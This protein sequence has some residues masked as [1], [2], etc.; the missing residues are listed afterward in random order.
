MKKNIII[1]ITLIVG[2]LL[3]IYFFG[4]EGLGLR[5]LVGIGFGYVLSRG[6]YGFAGT[7]NRAYRANSYKLMRS[8]MDLFMISS[9]VVALLLLAF[10]SEA[11]N[12][13]I[14]PINL[15]LVF[16]GLLFGFGMAGASCCASGV[17]AD[18]A[19]N[20]IKSLV[21]LFG[22]CAGVLLGFGPEAN[23]AIVQEGPSVF[24]P[25]YFSN[26]TIGIVISLIITFALA[27][28]V[29]K[30]TYHLD[31][32]N[33]AKGIS[34]GKIPSEQEIDAKQYITFSER[35]FSKPFTLTQ[36]AIG[37]SAVNLYLILVS[38]KGWGVSSTFGYW[39]GKLLITLGV[40]PVTV[41]DFTSKS[42]DYFEKAILSDGASI[43][44]IGIV[45]GAFAA[46]IMMSQL[47]LSYDI[48]IKQVFLLLLAGLLM[49]FGTRL[50]QG[51]NAGAF[52]TQV[53]AFSLSG[54][55]FLPVMVLG[56]ILGN[57]FFI[58]TCKI[59]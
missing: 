18:L 49:G 22:F 52:Y 10:G 44:N 28:G 24:L 53:T 11:F 43:Q 34:V 48:T 26:E 42:P 35:F 55:F 36:A 13:R 4:D 25:S 5:A 16:G 37:L 46:L 27:I 31:A 8:V 1:G 33:E 54:W 20:P 7:V 58:K 45:V 17:L 23:W 12:F 51:C 21:V 9:V 40:D 56:G 57:K 3:F 19:D 50:A 47:K 6:A 15:G 59:G 30:Y 41:A 14:N 2:Y 29:K 32:K 39:F 38:S